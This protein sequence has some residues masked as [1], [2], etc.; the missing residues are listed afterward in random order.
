MWSNLY[1]QPSN[2]MLDRIQEDKNDL[3]REST[4]TNTQILLLDILSTS[5]HVETKITDA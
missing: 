3:Q 4:G 1:F 2:N 5:L